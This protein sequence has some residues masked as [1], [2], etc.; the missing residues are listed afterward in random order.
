MDIPSRSFGSNLAWF[1][2]NDTDLLNL[3]NKDFYF[4]NQASWTV[5]SL[6]NTVSM[7]VISVLRMQH[8]ELGEWHQLKKSAK[9]VGKIGVPLSDLWEWN[10]GYRMPRTSRKLGSSQALQIAYAWTAMAEERKL[11]LAQSLGRSW[12]LAQR[13]LWPMKA[14]PQNLRVKNPSTKIGT[15]YGRMEEGGSTL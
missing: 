12:T 8:F 6:S 15:K 2:K 7:K 3:F 1:C 9:N 10:L 14:I 11:Q 5:F 13:L 4:P